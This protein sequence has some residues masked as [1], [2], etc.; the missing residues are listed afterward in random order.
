[1]N[2][3]NKILTLA[4]L[5]FFVG[6]ITAQTAIGFRA[7]VNIANVKA[8]GISNAIPVN[9]QS[10]FG[11]NLALVA[12]FG[13]GNNFALQTELNYLTRGFQVRES[14][15]LDL[16]GANV[17]LG[18]TAITKIN[19]LDIPV[20]AKYKFGSEKLS[21]YLTAGPVLGYALNGRL[22]TR[23]NFLIDVPVYDTDINL[24]SDNINRF[25]FGASLGAGVSFNTSA[26]NFFIDARY[27]QGFTQMDQISFLDLNIKNQGFGISA[28]YMIP[29]TN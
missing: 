9:T 25:E 26:G 12:E 11:P 29:L 14:I 13:L 6:Q 2:A 20:L 1:M 19:Y 15:D 23:A 7:G 16:F 21:A 28:G 10:I 24:S 27:T 5:F 4:F 22:E 3:T 18:A 8:F 17:P